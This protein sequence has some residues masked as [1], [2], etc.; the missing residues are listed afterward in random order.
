MLLYLISVAIW[1]AAIIGITGM[2]ISNIISNGWISE[3]ELID[4]ANEY[5]HKNFLIPLLIASTPV[6]RLIFII[7]VFYLAL[8]KKEDV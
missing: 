5:N 2:L 8:C 7:V 1:F 6:F 3:S 4:E